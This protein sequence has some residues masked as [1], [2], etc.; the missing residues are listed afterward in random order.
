ML[1][2]VRVF[3]FFK[4]YV[5]VFL[6]L[7]S[8]VFF[9]IF[10]C[11]SYTLKLFYLVISAYTFVICSLEINQ[12]INHIKAYQQKNSAYFEYAFIRQL[13]LFDDLSV[14]RFEP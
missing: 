4:F 1:A 8:L 12:S 14:F 13:Q 7:L 3:I 9:C 5:P 6:C 10:F 2:L 11:T